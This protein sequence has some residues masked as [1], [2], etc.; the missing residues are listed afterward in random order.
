MG[1][2]SI[3]E[4]RAETR[5]TSPDSLREAITAGQD[6]A[7]PGITHGWDRYT[8][9]FFSALWDNPGQ[10]K[11]WALRWRNQA[12]VHDVARGLGW[13]V[14]ADVQ[15]GDLIRITDLPAPLGTRCWTNS[16]PGSR[17]RQP[18][19][20]LL[21]PHRPVARTPDWV[22]H[23][24]TL[25]AATLAEIIGESERRLRIARPVSARSLRTA[26]NLDSELSKDSRREYLNRVF[27]AA[28]TGQE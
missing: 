18:Q 22:R 14:A 16:S 19:P 27:T 25:G 12:A 2:A 24:P 6:E 15:E 11:R 17:P 5:R 21:R 7:P 8:R 3:A 26:L 28:L 13:T 1:A 9:L 4:E 23:N 10:R 20:R